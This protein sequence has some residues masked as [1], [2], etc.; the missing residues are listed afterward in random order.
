MIHPKILEK[1]EE[2]YQ[3]ERNNKL[4]QKLMKYRPKQEKLCK[5]SKKHKR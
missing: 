4:G 3:M 1:Q 2:N 5:E